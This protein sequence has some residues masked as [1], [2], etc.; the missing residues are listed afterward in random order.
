M[1]PVVRRKK[2]RF[3]LPGRFVLFLLSS[4]CILLIVITFRTDIVELPL[5]T[6]AGSFIVPLQRGISRV[7][8]GLIS[9]D[10]RLMDIRALREENEL[11]RREVEEVTQAYMS[12]EQDKYELTRLRE[13]YKLD[14]Q[15]EEYP[16]V[17]ARIIAR[18][19]GNWYHAFNIDK[20]ADEGLS[21]DMNILAAGGLVGR[22]VD[23]GPDWAKVQTIIADNSSVSAMILSTQ[24]NMIVTGDLE[25]YSQGVIT[26]SKLVDGADRVKVGDKVVTSNISDKYL[27]GILIGYIASIE[28][29]SNHLTKSGTISVAVD[30]EHLNEVLVIQQLKKRPGGDSSAGDTR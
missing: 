18:D 3:V 13:L 28:E 6:F 1:S 2:E 16:K 9:I 11:L 7:G 29:D 21:V 14:E 15:Y 22:I 19:T 30:F 24:D 23:V 25:A 12:L 20:G 27:P 5:N 17:G 10:M 26:F 8:N 4:L